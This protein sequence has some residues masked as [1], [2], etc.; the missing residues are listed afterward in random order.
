MIH[1][2][3]SARK[4]EDW[5]KVRRELRRLFKKEPYGNF[6]D[7]HESMEDDILEVTRLLRSSEVIRSFEVRKHP[8]YTAWIQIYL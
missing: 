2:N 3:F 5:E 6:L 1:I 7:I 4:E 8:S